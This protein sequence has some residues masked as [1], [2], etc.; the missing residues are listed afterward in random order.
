MRILLVNKN[1]FQLKEL[2]DFF[3]QSQ[4]IFTSDKNSTLTQLSKLKFD[5]AL[6]SI[7]KISDLGLVKYINENYAELRVI[8]SINDFFNDAL[9]VLAE[10][11]F[12]Q[13]QNPLKLK[14]LKNIL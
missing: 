1:K 11:K 9:S 14:E 10:G 7:N 4:V 8:L 3:S 5:L 2:K 12:Q 13:I 6:I